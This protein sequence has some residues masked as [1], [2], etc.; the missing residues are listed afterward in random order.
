M[1]DF[2]QFLRKTSTLEESNQD[3]E[4]KVVLFILFI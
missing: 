4:M 2:E 3:T 1:N